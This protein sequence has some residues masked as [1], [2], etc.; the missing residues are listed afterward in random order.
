MPFHAT[1]LPAVGRVVGG[2]IS[3]IGNR[4]AIAARHPAAQGAA[5]ALGGAAIPQIWRGGN[6]NGNGNGYRAPGPVEWQGD[7]HEV[8]YPM[9]GY[10]RRR[11]AKGITAAELRGAR[12]IAQLVR[13]YGMKPKSGFI[14]KRKCK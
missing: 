9:P 1:I 8:S 4:A 13:L 3:R 10:P 11:R 2:V 14:G 5:G 7:P 12:K 6:G